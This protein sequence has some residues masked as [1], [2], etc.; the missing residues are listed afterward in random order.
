MHPAVPLLRQALKAVEQQPDALRP[1]AAERVELLAF[2]EPPD[3]EPPARWLNQFKGRRLNDDLYLKRG[4]RNISGATLTAQSFADG[5]R[6]ALAVFPYVSA[7]H[8][9]RAG[10][11]SP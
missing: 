11:P 6:R 8:Q 9:R 2:F 7:D 4:L 10:A 3:Y 1:I 5:V